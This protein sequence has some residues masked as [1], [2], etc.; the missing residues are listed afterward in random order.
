MLDHRV[1]VF[2]FIP[3][4]LG[5]PDLKVTHFCFI[6]TA[7]HQLVIWFKSDGKVTGSYLTVG[8]AGEYAVCT[9]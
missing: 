6:S 8:L 5:A 9:V 1:L 7:L 3:V 4:A 2:P